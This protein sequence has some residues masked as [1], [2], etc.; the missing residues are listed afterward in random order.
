MITYS[1][2][3]STTGNSGITV[4]LAATQHARSEPKWL[5]S[6]DVAELLQISSRTVQR[7]ALSDASMPVTRLGRLV[8]FER[9]ALRRWLERRTQGSRTKH[10][11][12]PQPSA[13]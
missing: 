4:G 7:I 6:S 2:T 5:I 8:R 3:L 12:G 10:S 11:N 9:Q 13:K 1:S